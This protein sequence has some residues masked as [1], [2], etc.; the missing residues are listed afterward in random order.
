MAPHQA[1]AVAEV[2]V[3]GDLLNHNTHGI[4]LL[5]TVLYVVGNSMHFMRARCVSSYLFRVSNFAYAVGLASMVAM[6]QKL[7][8]HYGMAV[9]WLTVDLT[10]FT[11]MAHEGAFMK[12]GKFLESGNASDLVTTPQRRDTQHYVQLSQENEERSRGKNL[13]QAYQKGESVFNL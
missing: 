11:L 1:K 4:R 6:L 8:L 13:R 2:A 7:Q 12:H 9:L 3:E 5:P 10:S